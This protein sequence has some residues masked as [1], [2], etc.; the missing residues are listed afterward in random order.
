MAQTKKN[1]KPNRKVYQNG[2]SQP[3]G[4]RALTM[5]C[6]YCKKNGHMQKECCKE[7]AENRVMINTQ[8]KPYKMGGILTY[9]DPE[10]T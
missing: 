8:G 9:G 6:R 4:N 3:Q 1:Q 10:R 2:G 5:T 7:M